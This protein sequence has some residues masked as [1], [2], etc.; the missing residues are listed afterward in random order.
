VEVLAG[1]RRDPELGPLLVVG[2]GGTAAEAVGEVAI[3]TLPCADEDLREMIDSTRLRILLA[4]TRGAGPAR[5][6]DLVRTLSALS[7][8]VLVL[9]EVTDVEVNPLR[10]GE[11]G[12]VALDARVLLAG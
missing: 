7:R 11:E 5:V 9:P 10:C 6:E 8:T 4:G 2:V 12:C 1:A 3:R